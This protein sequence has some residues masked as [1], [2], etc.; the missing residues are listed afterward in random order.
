MPIMPEQAVM[1]QDVRRVVEVFY[2]NF[3]Y[4]LKRG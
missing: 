2:L 1:N 4:F 3:I